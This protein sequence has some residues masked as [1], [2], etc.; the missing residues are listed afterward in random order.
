MNIF[1][2]SIALQTTSPA[3]FI[4]TL[5]AVGLIILIAVVASSIDEKKEDRGQERQRVL[6]NSPK[7]IKKREADLLK[8]QKNR[9]ADLLRKQETK[10]RLRTKHKNFRKENIHLFNSSKNL[11]LSIQKLSELIS[12]CKKC[13]NRNYTIWELSEKSLVYR[14]DVCK[15]KSTVNHEVVT[16]IFNNY[17]YYLKLYDYCRATEKKINIVWKRF[18]FDTTKFNLNTPLHRGITFKGFGIYIEN[19]TKC[20]GNLSK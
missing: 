2:N 1:L 15:K 7:D 5:V 16:Y 6:Y 3:M 19:L 12:Y 18:H 11:N 10:E 17:N 4:G 8:K 13:E 9:E 14:C 20:M